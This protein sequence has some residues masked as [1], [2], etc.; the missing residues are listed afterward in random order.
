[1]LS[2]GLI[3]LRTVASN[4]KGHF[5]PSMC[6]SEGGP[7]LEHMSEVHAEFGS[8]RRTADVVYWCNI[9][10]VA[11]SHYSVL[12]LRCPI[13]IVM[14]LNQRHFYDVGHKQ[15]PVNGGETNVPGRDSGLKSFLVPYAR[16]VLAPFPPLFLAH[17]VIGCMKITCKGKGGHC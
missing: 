4:D 10:G 16:M 17:Q 13:S 5:M 1:M 11:L 12:R 2:A 6:S 3:S 15:S 9:Y 7:I 14:W 8:T